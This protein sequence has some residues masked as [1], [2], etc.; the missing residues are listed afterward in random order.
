[1][2]QRLGLKDQV[3]GIKDQG[4][5]IRDQELGIKDQRPLPSLLLKV[6]FQDNLVS[7]SIRGIL[8]ILL[9]NCDLRLKRRKSNSN[10]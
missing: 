10:T 9:L 6:W 8:G 5:R 1:M 3:L 4:S 2:D 7:S